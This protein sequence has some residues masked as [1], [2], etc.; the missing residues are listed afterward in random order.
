[1]NSFEQPTS[2]VELHR[3][4]LVD[5][6]LSDYDKSQLFNT[7]LQWDTDL[8]LRARPDGIEHTAFGISLSKG[9]EKSPL[10]GKVW[11][12][13]NNLALTYSE[14]KE[15]NIQANLV[16][17]SDQKYDASV[18]AYRSDLQ[19]WSLTP[20]NR[21]GFARIVAQNELLTILNEKLFYK[22]S[23]QEIAENKRYYSSDEVTKQIANALMPLAHKRTESYLY[24]AGTVIK[25][26]AYSSRHLA[27][28]SKN[29][30]AEATDYSLRLEVQDIPIIPATS[31]NDTPV[32]YITNAYE[33]T[34]SI[35]YESANE[36][37]TETT[38]SVDAVDPSIGQEYVDML[39]R[40]AQD[41]E[42]SRMHDALQYTFRLLEA[43]H[44][45]SL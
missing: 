33:H 9:D 39:A 27:S 41:P 37:F 44:L 25:N 35:P 24:Q 21:P 2:Q 40:A 30:G 7:M 13:Y 31:S 29:E 10:Y 11:N 22:D 14:D 3:S 12:R 8:G 36:G 23:I 34:V 6:E 16:F 28:F 1:M 43:E 15:N 42:S 38:F 4:S 5:V 26:D 20:Y 18:L 45:Q 32:Q 19:T 17:K